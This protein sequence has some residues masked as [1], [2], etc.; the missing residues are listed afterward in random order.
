MK[1]FLP[2]IGIAIMV[3]VIFF[4]MKDV[5]ACSPWDFTDCAA[6]FLGAVFEGILQLMS[7]V[8]WLSGVFLNF[9]LDHTVVRMSAVI[10]GGVDSDGKTILALTG[11]NVAWKILRDL[12]NIAFI[13]LLVYEGIKMI[14]QISSIDQVRK[15]IFGIILASLLINFSLF[16]TK[17]LIDASNI[18]TIG[19]YNSVLKPP[20]ASKPNYGLSDE[21]IASLGLSS[22]YNKT[23]APVSAFG[24]KDGIGQVLIMGFGASA[25]ILV[26]SFVFFAVSILFI[27]RFVVLIFLL[28]LSPIAYMGMALP[29]MQGYAKDWWNALKSQLLFAPIFMLM[30]VLLL[31]LMQSKGFIVQSD[32]ASLLNTAKGEPS[33]STMGLI[34][35]FVVIIGLLI[36]S[37]I[38]AK[39]TATQGSKII[40][41]AT[42]RATA[43]AGGAIL[44]G[45]GRLGRGT[46][47]RAGAA[48]G[49]NE[50]LKERA[51]KGGVGGALARMSLAAANKATTSSFD[52]R[53]SKQF[54]NISK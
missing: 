33:F 48:A 3:V 5:Q 46:I 9:V 21:I 36:F 23:G 18:V 20:D 28:M 37:L 1:K 40:G 4:P 38:A 35:N 32:F 54:G 24:G 47:G 16:F 50:N 44:G 19:L 27:V 7:W 11:I 25:I 49:N 39:K 43:F 42:G 31:T 10:N 41:D 22:I 26:A 15:F 51:A 53:A 2:Y 45:A 13:F 34:V 29:F 8:L 12:M 14:I 52:V 17:V 6:V 30:M